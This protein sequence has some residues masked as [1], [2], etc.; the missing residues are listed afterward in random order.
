MTSAFYRGLKANIDAAFDEA[1]WDED[2]EFKG[3][4]LF[5]SSLGDTDVGID[6]RIELVRT[7]VK[8]TTAAKNARAM[9]CLAFNHDGR[10]E[11]NYLAL[12]AQALHKCPKPANKKGDKSLVAVFLRSHRHRRRDCNRRRGRKCRDSAQLNPCRNADASDLEQ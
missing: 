8:G 6:A 5:S 10:T 4:Y 7:I 3:R 12:A 2:E 1:G 11:A 9:F